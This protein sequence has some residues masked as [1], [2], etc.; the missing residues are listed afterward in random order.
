MMA[1]S[2]PDM[3]WIPC[4]SISQPYGTI[5]LPVITRS[6][7]MARWRMPNGAHLRNLVTGLWTTKL[8]FTS[9]ALATLTMLW[10]PVESVAGNGKIGCNRCRSVRPK[11][12]ADRLA[13]IGPFHPFS[14]RCLRGGRDN[15]GETMQ[16]KRST[17][18]RERN[19][20]AAWLARHGLTTAR[21][22]ELVGI[23]RASSFRIA[24]GS[25]SIP[26]MLAVIMAYADRYG[27]PI[28][29]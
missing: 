26:P 4:P 3:R 8:S 5:Q 16:G 7:S 15:T 27:L 28:R 10:Q 23:S 21:A 9:P 18:H 11:C 22:A 24:G 2:N 14:A 20:Y 13:P 29:D 12:K 1:I 25:Q 6:K 17:K 19:E